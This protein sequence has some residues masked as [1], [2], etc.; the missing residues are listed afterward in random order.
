MTVWW[1]R[2]N[3]LLGGAIDDMTNHQPGLCALLQH[4]PPPSWLATTLTPVY[5]DGEWPLLA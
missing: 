4:T 5:A 1:V 2:S 3:D